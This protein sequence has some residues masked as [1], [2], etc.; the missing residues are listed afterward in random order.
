MAVVN[1]TDNNGSP[2]IAKIAKAYANRK[3]AKFGF[4]IS[5]KVIKIIVSVFTTLL[6]TIFVP[7][8]CVMLITVMV[9]NL[10]GQVY[11]VE[12]YKQECPELVNYF[13]QDNFDKFEEKVSSYVT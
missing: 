1:D 12:Q 11:N 9:V 6:G 4:K 3:V 10:F 7:I 8:I 13:L 5:A 2:K